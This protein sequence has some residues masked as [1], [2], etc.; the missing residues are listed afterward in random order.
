MKVFVAEYSKLVRER[1]ISSFSGLE[2]IELTGEASDVPTAISN[3]LSAKP[4]VVI[5]DIRMPGGNGLDVLRR[6][7]LE[8]NAPKVIVLTNYSLPEYKEAAMELGADY[9]FDKSTE[10]EKVRMVL[11][12]LLK[13]IGRIGDNILH[14]ISNL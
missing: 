5:L 4:D 12:K 11:K 13:G 7:K 9:F 1:I 3:M 14:R 6:V 8:H 10:F 2:G